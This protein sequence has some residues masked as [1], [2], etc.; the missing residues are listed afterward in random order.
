MWGRYGGY[1]SAYTLAAVVIIAVVVLFVVVE[2]R[3]KGKWAKK[4]K[5]KYGL[6]DLG[7]L[8]REARRL[9]DP[10]FAPWEDLSRRLPELNSA[11]RSSSSSS[12]SGSGAA[13]GAPP[14]R[15]EVDL[16]LPELDA[17]RLGRKEDDW[18]RAYV[19]LGQV[20]HSYC[21]ALR[22]EEEAELKAAGAEPKMSPPPL[23]VPPQLAKPW[24]AVCDKLG[25]P[26]VLTAVGTD[27][28]NWKKKNPKKAVELDNMDVLSSITGTRSE[29]YFHL[30]PA[31][32]HARAG[33]DDFVPRLSGVPKMILDK[34]TDEIDSL[35]RDAA[36]L[37]IDYRR[38][39]EKVRKVVD[40]EEF[41]NVYRPYLA[42]FFPRGA[43]LAG[44]DGGARLDLHETIEDG[45]AVGDNPDD[46]VTRAKGPSAGQSTIV[47]LI[48]LVCGIEHDPAG[49]AGK[50]QAEM[51]GYMP[52]PHKAL[53]LDTRRGL[54]E[55]AET[56][57]GCRN[58]RYYVM[59]QQPKLQRVYNE[60]VEALVALRK[61]HLDQALRYL[62]RTKKGTGAST[63]RSLLQKTIDD[64]ARASIKGRPKRQVECD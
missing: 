13:A 55:C 6:T 42:G 60:A 34:D 32:M 5:V 1:L 15:Q 64:T 54:E 44:A 30:L 27:C 38:I 48:D 58:I 26:C 25:L 37:L 52:D 57:L 33:V 59:R 21:A 16:S 53:V 40:P 31:A 47:A 29:A 12:S 62:E 50:F 41:Y 35:L 22:A 8:G 4:I 61:F 56:P 11:T 43:R 46:I 19:L 28:W 24:H 17:A 7:F 9:A 45:H 3:R 10:Y 23:V 2:E 14:L 51:L 49:E 18:R 36:S 20:V 63:F 39:F